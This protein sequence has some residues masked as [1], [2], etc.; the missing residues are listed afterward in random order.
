MHSTLLFT[1]FFAASLA[2]PLAHYKLAKRDGNS[3]WT[4]APNSETTC[5]T[6]SDKII[7]LDIDSR[8]ETVLN[9]ACAAMMAPCAYQ[10]LLPPQTI[11]IQTTDWPLQGPVNSTQPADVLSSEGEKLTGW[12]VQCK[13]S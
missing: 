13:C 1:T 6:T 4:P 9:D 12:D 10:E 5:D 2:S 3:T 7:G 11:C 8:L